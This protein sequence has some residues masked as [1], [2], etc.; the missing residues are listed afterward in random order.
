MENQLTKIKCCL[1]P[2]C[3][4]CY[5]MWL[6]LHC[7]A[8]FL[9]YVFLLILNMNFLNNI[10]TYIARLF[11]IAANSRNNQI[12]KK[13]HKYFGTRFLNAEFLIQSLHHY[14]FSLFSTNKNNQKKYDQMKRRQQW[15][16]SI[17]NSYRWKWRRRNRAK[18]NDDIFFMHW[19]L[20]YQ[21]LVYLPSSK[22]LAST[23]ISFY[24]SFPLLSFFI[25]SISFSLWSFMYTLVLSN[26]FFILN[27]SNIHRE[28]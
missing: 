8:R 15:Q 5:F 22:I 23:T 16:N 20:V 17:P 25:F 28:T 3:Q 2:L 4:R 21:S 7:F 6:F 24:F 27:A 12:G 13:E 11:A 9:S 26:T 18:N 19:Q 14:T 10:Y 1:K